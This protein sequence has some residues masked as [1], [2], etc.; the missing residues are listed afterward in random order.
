MCKAGGPR[1]NGSNVPSPTQRAR[2]KANAAYR[3]AVA[4]AVRERTGDNDLAA[5]VARASATDMHDIAAVARLDENALA[6]SA[7]TATYTA[8]D[9]TTAEV[10][11]APT[12]RVRRTPAGEGTR[13]LL[14]DLDN[15]T[16]ALAAGDYRD[17]VLGA[18]RSRAK[19]LRDEADTHIDSVRARAAAIDPDT[20]TDDE[21]AALVADLDGL[22][23]YS[24]N[25]R[26]VGIDFTTA[27]ADPGNEGA[28]T[29]A[30]APDLSYQAGHMA[31]GFDEDGVTTSLADLAA[32]TG[33]MPKDTLDHPD[34]YGAE[35]DETIDALKRVTSPDDL[36]T[37]YRAVPDNVHHIN[38]GDW[39]TLSCAYA[40]GHADGGNITG[41]VQGHIISAQ[42]PA[43]YLYT[44]DS[45]EEWGLDADFHIDTRDGSHHSAARSDT[46]P[47]TRTL[48]DVHDAVLREQSR[49]R[50]H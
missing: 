45:L 29:G 43:K 6:A 42:V 26:G 34:W 5:R 44:E 30:Y 17:A 50:H 7:G 31:P 28:T 1:C 14:E 4:D 9:G 38:T 27:V 13:K 8:P 18:D 11:V 40:Q 2:R 25:H 39:V 23:E 48:A 10:P 24:E 37:I 35:H 49:R 20:A 46:A 33:N 32:G 36:V 16:G 15:A 19:A 22:Y 47:D 41:R 21:L 3:H 12:G